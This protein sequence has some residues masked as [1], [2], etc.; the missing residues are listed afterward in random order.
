M[1]EKWQS[2][3]QREQSLVIAMLAFVGI[4]ILYQLIWQPINNS[5]IDKQKKIERYQ[6]LLVWVNEK[7]AEYNSY[8]KVNQ[9]SSS[10]VSLS[11]VVNRSATK[12]KISISRIQPQGSEISVTIDEVPFD[13]VMDWLKQMA[14]TEGVIIKAIDL[15]ST[16]INGVVKVRRLSLG[17]G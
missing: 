15:A 4:F 10:N 11:S 2:L 5:I 3:N 16:D 1:K 8:A 13:H 9:G 14:I 17:K 6:E 12:H 7:K